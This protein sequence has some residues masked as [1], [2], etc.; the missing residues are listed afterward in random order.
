MLQE[1][2][3]LNTGPDI[4]TAPKPNKQHLFGQAPGATDVWSAPQDFFDKV[5]E[6]FDFNLDVCALPENAKCVSYFTPEDDG[7][8]QDWTGVC[9]MNPPYSRE[10]AQWVEKASETA[11]NGHTVVALLPARTDVGWW[12]DHCLGRE[13]HY[14]RGRLKFDGSKSNAPFG[15]ALVVFRPSLRDVFGEQ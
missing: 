6:V 8:A 2:V 14:I 10:I 15:C 12:Q 3:N 5:N 9:W 7:L 11:K 13:I 4:T 1:A